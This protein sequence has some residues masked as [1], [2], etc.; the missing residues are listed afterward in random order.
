MRLD[1]GLHM[2]EELTM[3]QDMFVEE[4]NRN[5]GPYDY[6]SFLRDASRNQHSALNGL[7]VICVVFLVT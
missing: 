6:P 2:K 4:D 1:Y 7:I 5:F 3:F